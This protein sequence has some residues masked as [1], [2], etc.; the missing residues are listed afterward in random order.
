MYK[1][2]GGDQKEYG[3]VTFDQV[4]GWIRDNRA[5]AQT[6]IQKEGGPWLP[7]GSLP[8]AALLPP[9]RRPVA[10]PIGPLRR[11]H[12]EGAGSFVSSR[13]AFPVQAHFKRRRPRPRASSVRHGAAVTGILCIVLSHRTGHEF[14]GAAFQ[15]P[16]RHPAGTTTVLRPAAADAGA[17][18]DR[19]FRDQP[20]ISALIIYAAQAACAGNCAR[21]HRRHLAMV[22]T[23][24]VAASASRQ[25]LSW[26]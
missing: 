1:I 2:I 24:R 21:C 23:S 5:N 14:T 22:L 8:D 18:G 10:A 26:S 4:A 6:L 9:A 25:H 13:S 12:P 17:H 20:A 19:E 3:P 11:C 16:R 15:P 7:L